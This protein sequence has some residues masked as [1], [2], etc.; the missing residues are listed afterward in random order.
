[1]PTKLL[2]SEYLGAGYDGTTL[3]GQIRITASQ[4]TNGG[5]TNAEIVEG[6]A[7]NPGNGGVALTAGLTY[8]ILSLGTASTSA[9]LKTAWLDLGWNS[10]GDSDMPVVGD[11]FTATGIAAVTAL[12]TPSVKSGDVRRVALGICEG[13][14]NNYRNY[15]LAG[16]SPDK[17]T[18]TRSTFFDDANDA[19]TRVYTLTFLTDVTGVEVQEESAD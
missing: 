15:D 8:T 14:Y 10:S 3:A 13:M 9:A 17:M 16:T 4:L 19:L 2:P 7:V 18:I 5:L 11:T 1:M 6:A 12:T